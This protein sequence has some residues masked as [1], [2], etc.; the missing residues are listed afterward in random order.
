MAV[1]ELINGGYKKI[2]FI[3]YNPRIDNWSTASKGREQGYIDTLLKNGISVNP[4]YIEVTESF[5]EDGR[6]AAAKMFKLKNPPDAIFC[7]CDVLALG[8]LRAASDLGLTVPKD[9][10]IMGFDDI[11][12]AEY[13]E[14]ST[15]RQALEDSG[16][17][18][19]NLVLKMMKD[20]LA[21]RPKEVLLPLD[22]IVR[23]TN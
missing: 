18:A 23:K 22:L 10:A 9:V 4:E 12:M 1:Q 3:G 21:N 14:L 7:A 11:E 16:R 5:I 17:E 15:I 20:P 2:A 8:A 19:V 13:L 6:R